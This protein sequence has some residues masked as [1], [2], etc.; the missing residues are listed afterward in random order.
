MILGVPCDDLVQEFCYTVR[1]NKSVPVC[2]IT[3]NRAKAIAR[4]VYDRLG[5]AWQDSYVNQILYRIILKLPEY[6]QEFLKELK[7]L[8]AK[9]Y[10]LKY[11]EVFTN[12]LTLQFIMN[13]LLLCPYSKR[14]CD[15][16]IEELLGPL[17]AEGLKYDLETLLT[18]GYFL[19]VRD[20][21]E[22]FL[23]SILGEENADSR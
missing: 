5:F 11:L 15:L 2:K 1:K 20:I 7:K 10:D 13:W 19:F 21:V 3:G 18:R 22:A 4:K 16:A 12:G 17:Q 6:D 9:N 8:C 14:Y 23:D